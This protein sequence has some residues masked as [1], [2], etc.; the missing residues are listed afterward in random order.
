MGQT[1][2]TLQGLGE[3]GCGVPVYFRSFVTNFG[4][5]SAKLRCLCIPNF[6][7]LL[8]RTADLCRVL[9]DKKNVI[10]QPA[11]FCKNHNVAWFSP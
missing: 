7:T 3:W 11:S 2:L 4:S 8:L 1:S 5:Y 9:L 10:L 6:R